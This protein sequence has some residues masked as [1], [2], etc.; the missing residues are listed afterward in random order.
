MNATPLGAWIERYFPSADGRIYLD[1][2]ACGPAPRGLGAAVAAFYDGPLRDG[3]SGRSAWRARGE[4]IRSRVAALMNVC[5]ADVEFFG[6]TTHVMNLVANAIRWTAGDE[7][8]LAGDEHPSV[9]T[10]WEVAQRAG[11]KLV[12]VPVADETRRTEV[13]LDALTPRT[14][15]LA[16]SHVHSHT[17]GRIE[18]NQMRSQLGDSRCLLVIDGIQA[19]GA[20]PVDASAADVYCAATFKWLCAGFGVAVMAASSKARSMMRPP[21][22]GYVNVPPSDGLQY[23]HWNH[24]CLWGLDYALAMFDEAG[25]QHVHQAVADNSRT[26]WRALANEGRDMLGAERSLAG[27]VSV[28]PQQPLSKVAAALSGGGVQATARAGALRLSAH[29]FVSQRQLEAALDR[30]VPAVGPD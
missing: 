29:A 9:R 1:T 17:G 24:P 13:L 19:L 4:A 26:L 22:R 11:A 3:I 6:N 27:I 21:F 15:V 23:S 30:L 14:L 18:L 5:P 20:I 16:A 10:I 8:V 7:I 28:R 2:A 12:V 25:W